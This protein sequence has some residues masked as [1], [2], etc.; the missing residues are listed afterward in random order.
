MS[1]H[2]SLDNSSPHSV[3]WQAKY[4]PHTGLLRFFQCK[5]WFTSATAEWNSRS[6]I[7]FLT[8]L[9]D[10]CKVFVEQA[11]KECFGNHWKPAPHFCI[12]REIEHGPP[13]LPW[14]VTGCETGWVVTGRNNQPPLLASL[15]L[16]VQ[17]DLEGLLVK[18]HTRMSVCQ[19]VHF[20]IKTLRHWTKELCSSL[21]S[22]KYII[23]CLWR[24]VNSLLV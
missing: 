13:N 21:N 14:F 4:W 22:S 15:H 9:K 3:I 6:T 7:S 2:P 20:K 10:L 24:Y 23:G 11:G 1:E 17:Q 16:K 8:F 12:S 5:S 18:S 19:L